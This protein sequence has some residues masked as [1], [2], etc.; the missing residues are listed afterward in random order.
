VAVSPADPETVY[1]GRWDGQVL[2][3]RD[4]GKTWV[5]AGKPSDSTTVLKADPQDPL[6]LWA[7]GN[8]G[9]IRKSTDGGNTWSTLT[10]PAAGGFYQDLVFAPSSPSTVYAAGNPGFKV[11]LRSTDAGA[12]W[13]AIQNGLPPSLGNLAVDPLQAGTIYTASGGDI[14]K[15]VDGGSTWTLVSSAFHN[16]TVQWLTAAP[17]GALYAAVRY[18][19]VY[20]SED[21][22]LS[23]SPLGAPPRPFSFTALAADPNDPCRVY[24]GTYDRGLLA[25]T[26]TGTAVCP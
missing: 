5:V 23:W 26:K 24:A 21:G 12:T 2:R 6:T 17:S 20:E 25:F 19:N 9:G 15:T 7:A 13:T 4:G 11:L 10:G 18:D 16:Q 3:S 22:G 8:N 14:Y 1:L